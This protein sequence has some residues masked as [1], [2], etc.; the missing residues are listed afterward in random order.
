MIRTAMAAR[1]TL[2][3][4]LLVHGSFSV[5][6]CGDSPKGSGF[7][8]S[9]SKEIFDAACR[10]LDDRMKHSRV[11]AAA[12]PDGFLPDS[13]T[14]FQAG[15]AWKA[16]FTVLQSWKASSAKSLSLAGTG[17]QPGDIVLIESGGERL[18]L[19]YVGE[20]QFAGSDNAAPMAR[21]HSFFIYPF[22]RRGG[23]ELNT[24]PPRWRKG[25]IEG[26]NLWRSPDGVEL[27][28]TEEA[29][30]PT[31][32]NYVSKQFHD[33]L[34]NEW[35]G[36]RTLSRE[37]FS[38]HWLQSPEVLGSLFAKT[39]WHSASSRYAIL[40]PLPGKRLPLVLFIG[41][42]ADDTKAV[43]GAQYVLF[44]DFPKAWRTVVKETKLQEPL[45]SADLLGK[46]DIQHTAAIVEADLGGPSGVIE[47]KKRYL[48]W[49]DSESK[50]A[51]YVTQH[52]NQYPASP[53]VVIG[54]SYG[55][56]TAL[57]VADELEDT[58][59]GISV[60]L[61]VTLDPVSRVDPQA[62]I[63]Q[64]ARNV[65]W[66]TNVYVSGVDDVSDVVAVVGGAWGHEDAAKKNIEVKAPITH[67]QAKT[68][69]GETLKASMGPGGVTVFD[70][71]DKYVDRSKEF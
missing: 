28:E 9:Q 35:S 32:V 50:I 14:L 40:R 54:H 61:V 7:A 58:G 41:G 8:N 66:W 46:A 16:Q 10:L 23:L 69:L 29:T 63:G 17:A 62:A 56:D 33:G 5:A 52:L 57:D 18:P 1:T 25:L 39:R 19:V 68:M 4:V 15:S 70:A 45:L 11:E 43:S 65:G 13:A 2:C 38:N 20:N 24:M 53:L 30:P 51:Q 27:D 60:Q 67:W 44:K 21:S 34:L 22:T 59:N 6:L 49:E 42:M 64:T 48:E 47:F 3:C 31:G 55:G 36:Y 26:H 71:L 37:Q 12:H